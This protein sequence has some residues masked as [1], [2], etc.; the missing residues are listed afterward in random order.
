[1]GEAKRR[2]AH[3]AYCGAPKVSEDHVPPKNIFSADRKN[4]ITVPSCYEHNGKWSDLDEKFRGQHQTVLQDG[5]SRSPL[6]LSGGDQISRELAVF[7]Y[8][9]IG[10]RLRDELAVRSDQRDADADR[11][12]CRWFR[13]SQNVERA[14]DGGSLGL[15]TRGKVEPKVSSKEKASSSPA[16]VRHAGAIGSGAG[17]GR[18]PQRRRLITAR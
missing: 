18:R 10:G 4:L 6:P 16:P 17:S 1:M 3:C 8:R 14:H 15:L 12:P 13:R 9:T 7:R 5:P 2:R 11:L